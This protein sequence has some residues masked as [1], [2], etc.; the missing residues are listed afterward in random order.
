MQYPSVSM[1]RAISEFSKLPGIGRKS[2]QRVVFYLLKSSKFEVQQL[3]EALISLKENVKFC[4]TCYNITEVD[5]C[6]IC[7][8]EKRDR[9]TICIV[10]EANDV[11]AL[12]RTSQ[13]KG[14]Y[15]VL[16]GA[17]SPLEGIGP[18]DLRIKEL[19][20]RLSDSVSEMIIATNPNAEGEATAVYLEKL[21]K[22]M[23]IKISRIA[24]GIPVGGDLEYADEITLARAIEGRVAL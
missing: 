23:S 2:A 19:M 15:H 18:D 11:L 6:H 3:A 9:S 21:I 5:P 1:E 4:T 14:L 12:E 17:L 16:G 24:R 10:E 8:N 13:Y 20:R 7:T 22:P